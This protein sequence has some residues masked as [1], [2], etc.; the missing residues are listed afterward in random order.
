MIPSQTETDLPVV[1]SGRRGTSID[2]ADH[3]TPDIAQLQRAAEASASREPIPVQTCVVRSSIWTIGGYGLSQMLRLAGNI[4]VSRLV[5][6]EAF[7]LMAIVNILIQGLAMFSDVG[8]E[9]V[10]VQ[11]RRGD[12][13]RFYNT[14][15]S[16]QVIRGLLLFVFASLLAWPAAELYD[17]PR[18]HYLLPIA[19]ST[20]IIAGLNSTA[21]FAVRR[22]MLLGRLTILE[23]TAQFVGVVV[24][25]VWAYYRPSV[26]ALI[27]GI[28]A[29]SLVTFVGSHKLI[30]HYR[31]WFGWDPAAFHELFHFGKWVFVSTMITFCAMQID[32]LMLGRLISINTL[33]VY[34]VALAIAQLPNMLLQA[35]TGAVLYPLLS[36][37]ARSS[38]EE[39]AVNLA[40]ARDI[41]L[42]IGL[43]AVT[44]I[45][46]EAPTFFSLLYDERYAAAGPLAQLLA[47]GVWMAIL[48]VT[49]ERALQALG[50]SRSLAAYNF[51][52]LIALVVAAPLGFY[53]FD[54][55][56]FI[57]GCTLAAVGGH[58]MLLRRLSEHGISSWRDDLR[59]TSLTLLATLFGLSLT[60]SVDTAWGWQARETATVLYLTLLGIWALA[61]TRKLKALRG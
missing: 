28:I 53:F 5:L 56:G 20:T 6:P 7:G 13:P 30:P 40:K 45:V 26:D 16:V 36:R 60:H 34:S 21:L 4:L 9:P 27:G 10:L 35:L 57:G 59:M 2:G 12:E 43:F 51:T 15:W 24:M 48:S 3:P 39:L 54:L 1:E 25:C 50:D 18:L 17:E 55:A 32:R 8:I 46:L 41:L 23:L 33:G 38:T 42:A 47:A 52:K 22:H 44:G 61:Q 31:N 14:A 58:L 37:F 19:A 11:H 29:M 49:L